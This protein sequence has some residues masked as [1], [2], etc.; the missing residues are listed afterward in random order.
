M[1]AEMIP[2]NVLVQIPK[3]DLFI[4]GKVISILQR[5]ENE[6]FLNPSK[7]VE[8]KVFFA[9]KEDLGKI[10]CRFIISRKGIRIYYGGMDFSPF[11][12]F[13]ELWEVVEN[14]LMSE[15]EERG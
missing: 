11:I 10:Y 15:K 1:C 6:F 7:R 12:D 2:E 5:M 8:E 14:K 4:T 9:T 13:L 3:T